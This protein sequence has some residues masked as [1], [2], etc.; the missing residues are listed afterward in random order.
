MGAALREL[1]EK[2]PGMAEVMEP[3]HPGMHTTDTID[4]DV[5]VPI[6]RPVVS[7]G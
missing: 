3:D 1:A 5:V 2:L 6:A 7:D 4:F